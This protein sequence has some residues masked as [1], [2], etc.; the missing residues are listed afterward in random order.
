M[1]SLYHST[2]F[3]LRLRPAI[4]GVLALAACAA[5][6]ALAVPN[7]NASYIYG[8]TGVAA[9][10]VGPGLMDAHTTAWGEVQEYLQTTVHSVPRR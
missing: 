8:A 4:L 6:G 3:A 5:F 9:P 1:S 10:P 7:A 2:K